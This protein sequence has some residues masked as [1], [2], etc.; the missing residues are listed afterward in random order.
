MLELADRS[1]VKPEGVL[2]DIFISLD[3]WEYPAHSYVLQPKTNIGGYP[4]ILGRLWL[5]TTNAYIGC[6]SGNMTI[7]HGFE[8]STLICIPLLNPS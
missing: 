6:Q 3:S 7:T 4:L 8:K 2:E 1:K 5:A